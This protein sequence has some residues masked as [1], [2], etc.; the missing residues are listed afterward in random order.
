MSQPVRQRPLLALVIRLLA[1]M[2]L[3]AMIAMVKLAGESGMSLPEILFWRQLPAVPLILLILWSRNSLA[4]LKTPRLPQHGVR[5][6]I[7]I[8]GMCLNFGA[9]TLLPLAEAT[10]F[11]FTSTIWAV[12]LSALILRERVGLWRWSAVLTG[13]IGILVITQPGSGHIQPLGTAVAL[14]AAFM[15]ALISIQIRDLAL[16]EDPLTIVFYFALLTLPVLG[17][18]LPFFWVEKSVYQWALLLGLGVIGLVGQFLLTAALR[19]GSVSSI[20]VMDY[21]GLIWSALLGWALFNNL[22]V[23][24]TWMGAPLIIAAGL[25]I[26]WREHRLSKPAS[27]AGLD[28]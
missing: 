1:V 18:V 2:T 25:L 23:A 7:G 3:S 14:G 9:V 22:P 27:G 5:A 12:I 6:A 28:S 17:M 26:A 20:I 13:F 21:S 19:Y 15:I 24:A 11:G 10:A 16:T 4:Q 8:V